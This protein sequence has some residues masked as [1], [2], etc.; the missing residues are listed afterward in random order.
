MVETLQKKFGSS[1]KSYTELLYNPTIPL[2]G[3]SPKEL[4]TGTKH[5]YTNVH[6]SVSHNSQKAEITQVSVNR[7]MEKKLW[8]RPHNETLLSQ[9]KEIKFRYSSF[10]AQMS[11]RSQTQKDKHYIIPLIYLMLLNI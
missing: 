3:I 4:K 8:S 5:L 7:W 11:E 9:L 6:N 10:T 2:L 1:S